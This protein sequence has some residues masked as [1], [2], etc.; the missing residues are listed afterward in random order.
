MFALQRIFS[1]LF[2]MAERKPRLF[3]AMNQWRRGRIVSFQL[4]FLR[5]NNNIV[6][7]ALNP[8]KRQK[9]GDYSSISKD[10]FC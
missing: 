9:Q 10:D 7:I 2:L 6:F 4:F 5:A 3:N 1:H 8:I